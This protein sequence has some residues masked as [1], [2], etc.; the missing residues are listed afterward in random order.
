MDS[1]TK[2]L[3]ET[4]KQT[5]IE[6]IKKPMMT[7]EDF[8]KPGINFVDVFSILGD[9]VA[10]DALYTLTKATI[11]EYMETRKESFN[12][13]VG[14]ETRGFLLGTI[15]ARDYKVPFVAVRKPNKLPAKVETL[16][17]KLEYGSG[18]L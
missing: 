2:K 10:F 13:V 4:E 1:G 17:Y 12:V 15:L 14:L 6:A 18:T 3:T 9:P 16:D 11:D 5:L 8:P 7:Y